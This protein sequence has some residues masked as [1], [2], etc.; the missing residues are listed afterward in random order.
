MGWARAGAG[1]R[2]PKLMAGPVVASGLADLTQRPGSGLAAVEK[3]YKLV[4]VGNL[5]AVLD[6]VMY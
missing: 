3:F 4:A 1:G 2:G 5:A 6:P